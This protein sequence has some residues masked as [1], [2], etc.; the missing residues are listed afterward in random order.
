MHELARFWQTNNKKQ[1]DQLKRILTQLQRE[2]LLMSASDWQFLISTMAARDY[3]EL[4]LSN[5]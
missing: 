1:D 5:H 2:L 4:R 3:A